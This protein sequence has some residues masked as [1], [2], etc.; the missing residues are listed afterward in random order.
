VIVC[1]QGREIPS[2]VLD[3]AA[4]LAAHFSRA[5]TSSTVP[6]LVCERRH[7]RKP[8][9]A[10]P[11]QVVT[12]RARTLFVEPGIA[13]DLERSNTDPSSSSRRAQ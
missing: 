4:R 13:D 7:V 6:V 11:G 12:E 3:R 1:A 9:K 8:R 10:A 5:R 2:Q